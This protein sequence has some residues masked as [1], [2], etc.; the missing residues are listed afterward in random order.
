MS[1]QGLPQLEYCCYNGQLTRDPVVVDEVHSS[2]G[3][4][5]RVFACPTHA[6]L[7]GV[8]PSTTTGPVA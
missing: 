1:E 5:T 3:A 8:A 2:S 7:Y 4:G 6:P